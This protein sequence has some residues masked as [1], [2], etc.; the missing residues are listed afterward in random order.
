MQRREAKLKQEQPVLEKVAIVHMRNDSLLDQG[1]GH[2][3]KEEQLDL[4]SI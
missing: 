3:N 1:G 2:G 4:K